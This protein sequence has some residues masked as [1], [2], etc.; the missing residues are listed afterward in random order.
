MTGRLFG[1]YQGI[2]EEGYFI[3]RDLGE[4]P[5]IFWELGSKQTIREQGSE[6][7]HFGELGRK[8]LFQGSGSLHVD[9][10]VGPRY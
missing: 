5:F 3:S 6:K 10:L 4:G 8:V 2:W 1:P 9:P 7:K